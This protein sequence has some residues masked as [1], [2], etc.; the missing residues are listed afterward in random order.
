[1]CRKTREWNIAANIDEVYDV[2]A[3]HED[4]EMKQNIV[5]IVMFNF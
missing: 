2:G 5:G 3:K 4:N 1:M